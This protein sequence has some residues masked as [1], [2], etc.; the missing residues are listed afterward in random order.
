MRQVLLG[1]LLI[2]LVAPAWPDGGLVQELRAH[3]Q[4]LAGKL[5]ER[6]SQHIDKLNRSADWLESELRKAGYTVD[7]QTYQVEGKTYH[8]LE[9]RTEKGREV[10]V[11]GAHYDSAPGTPGANDN[12][13]GCVA[14]LA[15]ARRL[16]G[17][18]GVRFALF[19][20]EE[21][22][23]FHSR[24]MGSLVYARHCKKRGDKIKA[25]LSLETMGYYSDKPGSQKYPD[26]SMEAHYPD[27]GNFIAFVSDEGSAP[28][29]QQV[30]K[31]WT[32]R[33]K[34]PSQVLIAPA[35]VEGVSWSDHWSFWQAGYPAL[36][37]T[38]TAPYRYPYYHNVRDT[39]DKVD[40]ESLARVVLGL[41]LVLRELARR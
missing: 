4:I 23:F 2:G 32:E 29:V 17:V 27:R 12:G 11:V 18:K 26:P 14:V 1:L 22:P 21:P 33:V 16:A 31:L 37:V 3:L 19:T 34:F 35:S 30:H 28:L 7:R 10:V 9:T 41:E 6:N 5:G 39:P 8:N 38:D 15:L 25:M 20:N 40:Y 24:V 13:T 36:M